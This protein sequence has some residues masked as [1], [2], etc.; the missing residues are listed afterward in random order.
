MTKVRKPRKRNYINNREMFDVICQWQDDCRVAEAD[1]NE[2]PQMPNYLAEC[3]MQIANRYATKPNFAYYPFREEM[4]SDSILTCVKYCK[5]FNREK[6]N[7]P[8][9]YFTQFVKNTFLQRINAEK[10]NLYLKYKNYQ[11]LQLSEQLNGDEGLAAPDLN[12]ISHEFIR[13]F[14][15]KML[16][17]KKRPNKKED[18]QVANTVTNFLED[19]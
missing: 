13:G 2:R 12:E 5:N 16:S 3:F 15:E 4:V 6:S 14:E 18:Q 19:Q 7:N 9:A 11:E 8:F 1:G 10:K 17:E